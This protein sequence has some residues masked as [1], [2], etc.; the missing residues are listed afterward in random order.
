MGNKII[1]ALRWLAVLPSAI[2]G[3]LVGTAFA[4]FAYKA[5]E[6]Y[7]GESA[8]GVFLAASVLSG[9]GFVYCGGYVA[10][11]QKSKAALVL[12]IILAVAWVTLSV[13]DFY[14]NGFCWDTLKTAIT[15]VLSIGGGIVACGKIDEIDEDCE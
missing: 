11:T 4:N 12:T 6:R 14:S 9:L 8:L 7:V 3:A 15:G 1:C 2:I 5:A 13:L 10:P